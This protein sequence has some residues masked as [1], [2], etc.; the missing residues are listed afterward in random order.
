MCVD[1]KIICEC[2]RAAV[3]IN[4]K[5]EMMP[6]EVIKALYCPE[7]SARVAI[8]SSTMLS[9]NGWVI[10]YD[11]EIASFASSSKLRG[12]V[13]LTPEFIFDEGYCTWKGVYPGDVEESVVEKQ[14]L[15]E[16]CRQD[17]MRYV[18][19]FR[20]WTLDRMERLSKSGWRKANEDRSDS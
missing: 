5:D 2:G 16:L 3:S 14:Q 17:K 20:R 7:C 4:L 9:D 18:R 6:P 13:R 10:D 11:M 8:D 19:E 15:L 1:H 12:G